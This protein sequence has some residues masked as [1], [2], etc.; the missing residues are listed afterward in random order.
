[1]VGAAAARAGAARAGPP[2]HAD[3]VAN[4]EGEK[5]VKLRRILNPAFHL[6]KLKVYRTVLYVCCLLSFLY[7]CFVLLFASMEFVIDH[8]SVDNF[9][10]HAAGVFCVL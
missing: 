1:V 9:A 3:G 2:G 6:E 5:W 10:V 7:S 8:V 4:Y